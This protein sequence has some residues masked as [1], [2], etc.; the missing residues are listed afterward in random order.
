VTKGLK[1][2]GSAHAVRRAQGLAG[3]VIFLLL[4]Q[5]LSLFIPQTVLP[6]ASTVLAQVVRLAGNTGFLSD[7]GATLEAWAVGMLITVLVGVPAGLLLGSLPG[8]RFATM[9]V[10]EFL[11]P[12][13]S[14]SL[15][16]LVTLVLGVGLRMTATLIV[17]GGIWP[18][19]YNAIAGMDDV[20]PVAKETMRAFGFGRLAVI[21]YVSLPSAAPFIATGIRIAS[22][23]ALILDIGAGY[24]TGRVNGPGIGAYIADVSSG[25]GGL[26]IIL[27]ATAWAGI[28][29]VALNA[30]LVSAERRLLPWHRVSLGLSLEPAATMMAA[31]APAGARS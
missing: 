31:A 24:I 28:L 16:L 10:I 14:V 15:I 11:R 25:T 2:F 20:D 26:A 8:V 1:P 19:L 4:A 17:Y 7:V 27:A 30:L 9:K 23:V 21:R 3:I 12:I 5:A 13:P 18:V 29:G 22:S 6:R